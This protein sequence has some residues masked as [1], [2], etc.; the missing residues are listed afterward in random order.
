VTVLRGTPNTDAVYIK[1]CSIAVLLQF[2]V[3][4]TWMFLAFHLV[5]APDRLLSVLLMLAY[6]TLN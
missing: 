1:P 5:E 4:Q 6:R 3:G 2:L